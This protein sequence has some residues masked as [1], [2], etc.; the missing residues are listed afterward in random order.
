MAF[1]LEGNQAALEE[2]PQ[3]DGCLPL[4]RLAYGQQNGGPKGSLCQLLALLLH[5]FLHFETQRSHS[6]SSMVPQ[7]WMGRLCYSLS[8]VRDYEAVNGAFTN[9]GMCCAIA[10]HRYHAKTHFQA[11]PCNT[12][13]TTPHHAGLCYAKL[14][15]AVLCSAV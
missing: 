3:V 11:M 6:M 12:T 13:H 10:Q 5:G 9:A 2:A 14:S 8:A 15:H 1:L 4:I 7:E